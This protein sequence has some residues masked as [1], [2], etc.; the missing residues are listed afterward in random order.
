MRRGPLMVAVKMVGMAGTSRTSMK[1]MHKQWV[2]LIGQ[3]YAGPAA[4]I[5]GIE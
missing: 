1:A 3:G 2:L 5:A 4:L